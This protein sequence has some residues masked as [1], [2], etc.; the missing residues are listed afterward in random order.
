M[1]GK[2]LMDVQVQLWH[3]SWG[4]CILNALI[5][6]LDNLKGGRNSMP[7][8]REVLIFTLF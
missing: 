3:L 7:E 5:F 8:S 2:W 6:H 1:R 4:V